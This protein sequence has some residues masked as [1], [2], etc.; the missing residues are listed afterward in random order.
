MGGPVNQASADIR[1]NHVASNESRKRRVFIVSVAGVVLSALIAATTIAV[2][3]ISRRA[4]TAEWCE[5]ISGLAE[6]IG[7][8]ARQ[9]VESSDEIL[10]ELI[11]HINSLDVSSVDELRDELVNFEFHKNLASRI[12]GAP[13]I[14]MIAV[15][16]R[17]G[18]VINNSLMYVAPYIFSQWDK[19]KSEILDDQL[20]RIF[21]GLFRPSLSKPGQFTVGLGRKVF[22]K[23]GEFLAIVG[24]AIRSRHFS[25][26][27]NSLPITDG[28]AVTLLNELGVQLAGSPGNG[29]VLGQKTPLREFDT[30]LRY[31]DHAVFL[32]PKR[33]MLPKQEGV[34]QLVAMRRT[35]EISFVA[36]ASVNSDVYLAQWRWNAT[37]FAIGG[38]FFTLAAL[39]LTFAARRLFGEM[40]MARASAVAHAGTKT[41]FL[42]AM[43]HEMR[44]PLNAITGSS[45]L[46]LGHKLPAEVEKFA[47]TIQHSSRH[48]LFLI[49]D[50]LD[51]ARL[52][53]GKH[54]FEVAPFELAPILDTIMEIVGSLPGASKL[55]ISL[56]ISEATPKFLIG[57]SGAMTQ[58]LL[59]LLSNAI[60]FT[61]KGRVEL[62]VDFNRESNH[63][64]LE[65]SD[66]GCGITSAHQE[67]IFQPFE[68]GRA[69]GSGIQGAGLGLTIVKQLTDSIGGTIRLSA[70]EGTGST[71]TIDLPMSETSPD[72]ARKCD[73]APAEAVQPTH[74]L[75]LLVA[76]DVAANRMVIEAVLRKQGHSVHLVTNGVEV[77]EALKKW[78]FDAILMDVQMPEMD[79]IEATKAVRMMEGSA[80]KILIIGL[81]AFTEPEHLASMLAAG[82][83]LCLTK[84]LQTPKLLAALARASGQAEVKG[85]KGDEAEV[86]LIG[87][88]TLQKVFLTDLRAGRDELA[89]C[90]DDGHKAFRLIHKLQGLLAMFGQRRLAQTAAEAQR[91]RQRADT[92]KL[93]DAIDELLIEHA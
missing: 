35:P 51:F 76:E 30:E 21:S 43:S 62:R 83:D 64:R 88:K 89:S 25:D 90:L 79:G 59:N 55:S 85:Q 19:L 41:R 82:M 42:S 66:T 16:D 4:A 54:R 69:E 38:G 74:S 72:I 87:E 34:E 17:N 92:Q 52:E 68:R 13:H 56:S 9:T 36:T 10:L 1:L 86:A 23:S 78:S 22:N 11:K 57:D 27:Y 28:Y 60:K 33:A 24:V 20:D 70:V 45:E 46:L 84:P 3:L 37:F 14:E 48:L 18:Y 73:S 65:V 44:T 53:A 50:I 80:G 2:I 67:S 58:I 6:M 39:F 40:E 26:F 91:S 71:F 12:K 15:I 29:G 93:L 31:K 61:E 49:N 63:L 8:H 75:R 5:R 47:N 81:T 7:A 32:T 77:L